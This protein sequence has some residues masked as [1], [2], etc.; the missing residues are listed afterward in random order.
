MNSRTLAI[1][2]CTADSN[3]AWYYI[4]ETG[5]VQHPDEVVGRLEG[6]ALVDPLDH[7]VEEAT[8][9]GLGQGVARIVSLFHPQRHPGGRG[10]GKEVGGGGG[11][12][13]T[14]G[15]VEQRE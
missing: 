8:V 1:E 13:W 10:G 7:V 9:H 12:G 6:E 15:K 2:V 3:A 11:G 14:T 5:D 4:T